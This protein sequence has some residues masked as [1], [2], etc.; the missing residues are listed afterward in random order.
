MKIIESDD[1]QKGAKK[2]VNGRQH[3]SKSCTAFGI[4]NQSTFVV[5]SENE[6][7]MI[8]SRYDW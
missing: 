8:Y 5:Q 2:I 4:I 1:G 6:T 7:L 3:P